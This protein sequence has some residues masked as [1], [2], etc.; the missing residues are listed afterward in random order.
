[1]RRCKSYS[2]R[3][4]ALTKYQANCNFYVDRKLKDFEIHEA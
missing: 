1:M 2:K 3:E 4:A